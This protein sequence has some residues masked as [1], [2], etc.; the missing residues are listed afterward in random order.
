MR[1]LQCLKA[2]LNHVGPASSQSNRDFVFPASVVPIHIFS[3]H[4]IVDIMVVAIEYDFVL[5]I[6]LNTTNLIESKRLLH[7]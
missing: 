5:F 6:M 3:N 4:S 1:E 2:T 7:C